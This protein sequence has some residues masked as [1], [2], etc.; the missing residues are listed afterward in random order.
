MG[1]TLRVFQNDT[2][3]VS[4]IDNF[5][6]WLNQMG[7]QLVF[8]GGS[9]IILQSLFQETRACRRDKKPDEIPAFRISNSL[10]C[11]S[12]E[13]DYGY[14]LRNCHRPGEVTVG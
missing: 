14:Q 8:E 1:I 4:Q 12:K 9:G 3:R 6:G 11:E 7:Q 2:E 13:L 10:K 5:L